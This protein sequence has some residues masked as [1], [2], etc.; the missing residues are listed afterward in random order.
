MAKLRLQPGRLPIL[1]LVC[2]F[3]VL[4]ASA[5]AYAAEGSASQRF[6]AG[7]RRRG[8]FEL[9]ETYCRDRLSRTDLPESSRA[10]LVI[11]L[12]RSLAQWAV[13]SAPE[14]RGPL[15]ERAGQ[16][17][18]EFIHRHPQSPRL[19]LVRLQAAL[20]L[21]A[22]GE[23][24]RE[25]AQL[26]A[27]QQESLDEARTQLRAAVRQ[28]GELAEAVDEQ[29]LRRSRPAGRDTRRGQL[30]QLAEHQLASLEKNI[31]FQL[32]RALSNQGQCYGSDSEDRANS[33]TRAVELLEPLTKLDSAHPLAWKSRIDQIVCC[34]LM[35]DYQAAREKLDA[36][37]KTAPPPA[38]ALRMRAEGVR[39]ALATGRLPQAHAL[40]SAGRRIEG[41]T[42]PQLDYAWLETCLAEWRT[43]AKSKNNRKAAE[44]EA[45]ASE[46]VGLIENLHGPYWTRRAEMLL[47]NYVRQTPESGNLAMLV[48]AAESSY[49][50]GRLDDALAGYDRARALAAKQVGEDRAFELGYTAAT[51]EHRRR[52]HRKALNRYRQLALAM[53]N[54]P[55]AAEAHLLAV[56]H[57]G[58]MAG[59]EKSPDSLAEYVGLMQEHLRTWPRGSSADQVRRQ[60]GQLRQNQGDWQ[61]AIAAYSGISADYPQYHKVIEDMGRCYRAWLDRRKAAGEPTE[62]IAATA[63]GWFESLIVGPKQQLPE[64][65]SPLAQHAALT[66]ARLWLDYTPAG[67]GRAERI[68]EEALKGAADAPPEWKSHARTLLVF[69]LA[70]QGRSAEAGEVLEG[71]AAAGVDHMLSMLDR[72]QRVAATAQPEVRTE[73]AELQL[74]A[75]ELLRRS[76]SLAASA[77]QR[78]D[79]IHARA[80]ADAGRIDQALQAYEYLS[81]AYPRDGQIQEAYARLSSRREDG[82]S[83]EAALSKWRSV[84]KKSQ[85]GSDRWFR[86]KYEVASLQLRLGNREQAARIITLLEVLH[87][88]LGGAKMKGE[89]LELLRRC[90]EQ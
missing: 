20:G 10:E 73:L 19:L 84:A 41:L 52:R 29:L 8:L 81:K 13:N 27:H 5:G 72:L 43:A 54:Q 26:S 45:K 67:Y 80:L 34:R 4:P 71:I 22:R 77:R 11:E 63:A 40:L 69:A 25:E 59:Q 83:L 30:D 56:Y 75:V 86:A 2:G 39:L 12:S 49:R 68:I 23:L 85:P 64:H 38:V 7:L 66:A 76:D 57:A 14:A 89:F 44:W 79:R 9:A 61:N 1:G 70:G 53:P 37:A 15:W 47:A 6:L 32:A 62:K 36:L 3:L 33:L 50:S 78:L 90:R 28:L 18:E 31:R 51:I 48:R 21:L 87:P 88:Q 60:L 74:R 65:W 16:V 58:Q 24:A 46:V 42:S 82:P 17:A 55:K 35:A